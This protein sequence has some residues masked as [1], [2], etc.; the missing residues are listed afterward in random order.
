MLKRERCSRSL[1]GETRHADS[2][3]GIRCDHGPRRNRCGRARGRMAA[4]A[5]HW[6]RLRSRRRARDLPTLLFVEIPRPESKRASLPAGSGEG[7]PFGFL[8]FRMFPLRIQGHE[9]LHHRALAV[10]D[11]CAGTDL[12]AVAG[13]ARGNDGAC[14]RGWRKGLAVRGWETTVGE[15]R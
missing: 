12:G 6:R 3:L 2:H 9:N 14:L 11:G 10:G 15:G 8:S 5:G 1:R 13:Y 4:H 7:A